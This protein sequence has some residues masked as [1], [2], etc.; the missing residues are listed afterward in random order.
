MNGIYILKLFYYNEAIG[1]QDRYPL[2]WENTM[3]TPTI[4]VTL[5]NVKRL[6]KLQEEMLAEIAEMIKKLKQ[7]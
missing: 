1:K 5:E 7:P 4:E 3:N 2:K 6:L